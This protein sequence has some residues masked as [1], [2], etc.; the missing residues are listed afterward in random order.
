MHWPWPA[1]DDQLKNLS[2]Q[3]RAVTF[4]P[5]VRTRQQAV[6]AGETADEL[7]GSPAGR[8]RDAPLGAQPGG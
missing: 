6:D 2:A 8:L 5:A 4:T 3:M 1:I 7:V